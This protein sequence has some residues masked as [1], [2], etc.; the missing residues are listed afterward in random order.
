MELGLAHNIKL[1]RHNPSDI[2]YAN[3]ITIRIYNE[4]AK[5][6]SEFIHSFPNEKRQLYSF[7]EFIKSGIFSTI[8]NQTYADLLNRFFK[9]TQLKAILSIL[10]IELLGYDSCQAS[11]MVACLLL[12]EFILDGGYYPEN[13]I[14]AFPDGLAKTYQKH[15]GTLLY[16]TEAQKISIR[17]NGR[18]IIKTNSHKLFSSK[19]AIAACDLKQIFSELT[20]RTHNIL[21][22]AK[23]LN[24][25]KPSLSAFIVY[26]GL[27]DNH[28]IEKVLRSNIWIFHN[29]NTRTFMNN[30]NKCNSEALVIASSRAKRINKKNGGLG[31]TL[32]TIVPYKNKTFWDITNRNKLELRL[33]ETAEKF[34]PGLSKKIKIKFNACPTTLYNWT[35]NYNGAAYGWAGT[36]EQFGNPDIS[37]KTT[38]P[39]FYI[40]G[41]WSNL[42]SGVASVVNCRRTAAFQIL[43]KEQGI[44]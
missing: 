31:I 21:Q 25:L 17:K 13:G 36:P 26:I 6:I 42:G 14:Q 11:S 23:T 41:H 40:T 2:I 35:R 32:A 3:G 29:L 16:S 43:K 39:N 5:T 9:D 24:S 38:V 37:Q 22:T 30:L 20:N 19:Y 33:I 8:R 10:V 4:P 27:S 34:I 7:F 1:L 18:I 44:L 12:R 28:S 15:G